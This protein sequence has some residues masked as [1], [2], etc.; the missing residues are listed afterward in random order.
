MCDLE[1]ATFFSQKLHRVAVTK[2]ACV[3]G[4]KVN[5]TSQDRLF[6]DRS[7][8]SETRI[9]PKIASEGF[10]WEYRCFIEGRALSKFTG[11]EDDFARLVCPSRG[12]L[13]I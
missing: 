10:P 9:D 6:L 11:C 4:P 12:K 8:I 1:V 3:N 7:G 2:I 5:F 13:F